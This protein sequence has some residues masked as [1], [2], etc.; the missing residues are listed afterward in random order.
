M[1]I[2]MNNRSWQVLVF[3]LGVLLEY[4][5]GYGLGWAVFVILIIE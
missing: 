5:S 1:E 2:V 3:A 4:K